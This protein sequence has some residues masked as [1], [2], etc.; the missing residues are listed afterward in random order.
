MLDFL[1]FL[2]P[3]VYFGV[4]TMC[5]K[6]HKVPT[7]GCD[8]PRMGILQFS[9]RPSN[10]LT[11]MVTESEYTPTPIV[12]LGQNPK[13]GRKFCWMTP[14]KGLFTIFLFSVRTHIL[15]SNEVWYS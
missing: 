15:D 5:K 12:V 10:V 14:L 9:L 6:F 7:L 11:A 13:F 3:K 8:F 4:K 2:V 1:D